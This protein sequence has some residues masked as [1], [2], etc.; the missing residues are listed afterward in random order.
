MRKEQSRFNL[1][2]A[3]ITLEAS[4]LRACI[5]FLELC[6]DSS[7]CEPIGCQALRI[8]HDVIGLFGALPG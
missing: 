7:R 4:R 5:R 2:L 1:E 8:D 6:N 3:V